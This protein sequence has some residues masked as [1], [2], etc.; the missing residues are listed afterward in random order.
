MQ[1]SRNPWEPYTMIRATTSEEQPKIREFM[2]AQ[3][4]DMRVVVHGT[5][6]YPETLPA[7]V[8]EENGEWMGLLTYTIVGTTCEIVTLDSLR[9]GQGI[10]AALI[11]TVVREARAA[12]CQ[13]LWLITTND[14]LNALRFYQKRGFVLVAVHREAVTRAR[15]MKPTI[16]LIGAFGIP[17]RDEIELEMMV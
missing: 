11:D 16:P 6:Y 12:G 13:R 8:A 10:G 4:G 9:E 17:I 3:W 7:F 15:Q 1:E 14:N 2:I 5:E